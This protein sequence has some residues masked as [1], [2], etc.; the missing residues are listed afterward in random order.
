M[1]YEFLASLMVSRILKVVSHHY[2]LVRA[3]FF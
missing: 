3:M 2:Q 1:E